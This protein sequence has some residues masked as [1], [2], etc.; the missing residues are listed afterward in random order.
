MLAP[1][2]GMLTATTL[3]FIDF[4]SFFLL[5]STPG[6]RR[7][8]KNGCVR[9]D[10]GFPTPRGEDELEGLYNLMLRITLQ[11][12]GK[13]AGLQKDQNI[14][15]TTKVSVSYVRYCI[16]GPLNGPVCSPIPQNQVSLSLRDSTTSIYVLSLPIYPYVPHNCNILNIPYKYMDK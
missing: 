4:A 1:R 8:P 9:S 6:Q 5:P 15:Y 16:Y 13:A 12:S 11:C 3:V 2:T 10:S 14:E 7:A